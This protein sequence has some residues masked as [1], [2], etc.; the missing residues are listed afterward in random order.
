MSARPLL[1]LL[2]LASCLRSGPPPVD[3]TTADT[4]SSG[5]A[6][7]TTTGSS[8]SSDTSSSSGEPATSSSTATTE[9]PPAC[10]DGHLDPGEQ[11]DDG[12]GNSDQAA[13]K[14]DCTPQACGD[15]LL[16]PGELCDDGNQLDTD[17]CTSTCVPAECGDSILQPPEL[18]DDGNQ[19][20][21]DE[22]TNACVLAS[23]GDGVVQA[24]EECDAAGQT[25]ACDADCTLPVCNDGVHNADAGE[26][27][28]DGN[29]SSYDYCT[30][31]CQ[32][33][34]CGDGYKQP[35]EACDD[36]NTLPS[37]GCTPQ[38]VKHAITCQGNATLVSIA[39]SSRIALCHNPTF[40]E[41][42][43][44][45]LCPFGWHLCSAAEFNARNDTW[46]HDPA[47]LVLGG[48]RCL[49]DGGA[50]HF[51]FK[52]ETN[53]DHADNCL[54]SS[55]RT[56]CFSEYGCDD[57]NNYALCCAPLPFCGDGDLD[58]EEQCDDGNKDNGDEC[59]S[60]CMTRLQPDAQ[61][62]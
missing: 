51:G 23:C 59:F 53:V 35:G 16:G 26:P 58:P 56:E 24:P 20:D 40:C 2:A 52:H 6:S 19:S 11:C 15:G 37:D 43:Y 17:A 7:S 29:A 1:A 38:C 25:A 13:C 21:A 10:G 31:D 42:D 46:I 3:G 30:T 14:L 34:A 32:L 61:A 48:I 55:T 57:K 50:G 62:C 12:P 45:D 22:C 18:C 47:R 5:D 8:S 33:P 44:G 9:L 28:D 60:N 36:G 41:Q 39:P 4:S 54:Y 27:C 49:G